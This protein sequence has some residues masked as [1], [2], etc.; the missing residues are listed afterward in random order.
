[1]S[2]GGSGEIQLSGG[3]ASFGFGVGKRVDGKLD[4]WLIYGGMKGMLRASE[5]A[6]IEVQGSSAGFWGFGYLSDRA[7]RVSVNVVVSS[8]G[9]GGGASTFRLIAYGPGGAVLLQEGGPV[10]RGTVSLD[11]S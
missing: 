1:M 8:G 3:T 5:F 2:A 4:G 9:Q 10:I 7:E 11:R 6:S